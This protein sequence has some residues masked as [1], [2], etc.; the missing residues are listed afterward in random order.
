METYISKVH[1]PVQLSRKEIA[2]IRRMFSGSKVKFSILK[3]ARLEVRIQVEAEANEPQGDTQCQTD[4]TARK[5][6]AR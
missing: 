2:A 5:N 6:A 1:L 4:Q 3:E